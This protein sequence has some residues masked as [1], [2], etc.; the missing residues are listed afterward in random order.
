M[1]PASPARARAQLD[2]GARDAA[3]RAHRALAVMAPD[4]KAAIPLA[5]YV[6]RVVFVDGA[7]RDVDIEPLLG[8]E[9]SPPCAIARSSS[10]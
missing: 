6:V 3:A 1:G 10:G 2:A 9:I 4:V 5:S 7:V 8:G